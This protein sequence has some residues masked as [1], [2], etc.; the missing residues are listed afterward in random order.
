MK[1]MIVLLLAALCAGMAYGQEKKSVAVVPTTGGSVSQDIRMGISNGLEEGVFNSGRYK[2]VARGAAFEKA[3]GELKFQ[4]SGL[5]DDSQ[6]IEFG[7]ATRADFVCYA[8]V[9]K[10]SGEEY[11]ISYKMIDVASGEIVNMGKETVRNGVTGLLNATDNIA[12]KLFSG[13]PGGSGGMSGTRSHPA[14]PEMVFVQGGTFRMGST[15]QQGGDDDEMPVHEVT[16]GDFYIGK[17]E[18]KQAQWEVL[19]GNNPSRFKGDNLP[20]ESVSWDDVQRFIE[21][22]NAATGKQYR[23]P[24]E[25]EWEYAA[26]GGNQGEGYQYSGSHFIKDIAWFNDNSG[27]TTHPV[28]TKQSNELGIHDMSGNVYEWCY[29]CYGPY[30]ASA[31][32][33]PVGASSGFYRVHRGGCFYSDAFLCH[34]AYRSY[35]SPGDH[36]Y[37]LGFRLACSSK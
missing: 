32:Y 3:F 18:I 28:G 24:T 11:R 31:Q 17:Y 8:T 15:K 12:T 9:S 10:Y 36:Y 7:H 20:V 2:L 37:Q 4:Q 22:L 6:L 33:N 5:V 1:K 14:E 25:A 23:L 29:D 30:P 19:M 26:R 16:V 35:Y 27:S 34:V 13:K 21:R